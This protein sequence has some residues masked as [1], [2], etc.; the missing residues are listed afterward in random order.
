MTL[1]PV[2]Y[3]Q[4]SLVFCSVACEQKYPK[5]IGGRQFRPVLTVA[6]IAVLALTAFLLMCIIYRFKYSP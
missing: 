5:P 1:E 3:S 2:V 4:D 6:A